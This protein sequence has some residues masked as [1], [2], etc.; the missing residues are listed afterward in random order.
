M[1]NLRRPRLLGKAQWGTGRTDPEGTIARDV[2]RRLPPGWATRRGAYLPTMAGR[3]TRSW[4]RRHPYER[5]VMAYTDAHTNLGIAYRE[6]PRGGAQTDSQEVRQFLERLTQAN[7]SLRLL[8]VLCREH[9]RHAI[10]AAIK[11]VDEAVRAPITRT[12][13]KDPSAWL[14]SSIECVEEAVRRDVRIILRE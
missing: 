6:R 8:R 13:Y 2:A 7:L 12:F 11:E 14:I 1:I 10:D 9:V 4:G 5:L 3:P